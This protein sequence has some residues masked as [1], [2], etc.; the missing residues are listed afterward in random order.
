MNKNRV[1]QGDCLEVIA[2]L[3][4]NSIDCVITSPPYYNSAHKYQRGKGYHYVGDVGEPLYI[5]YDMFEVLKPKLK[6]DG[7]VC[8]NLG[9]SYG[10]TGVMRPYDVVNRIRN[11][12]GYFVKEVRNR[13]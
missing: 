12:L 1:I 9:F 8:L 11:K 2:G 10:E 7:V 3:E 6:E 5:I 4:D 13:L